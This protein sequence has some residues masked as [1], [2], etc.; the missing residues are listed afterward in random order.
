[1]KFSVII[2]ARLGST[3]LPNKILYKI[4]RYNFLE[5]LIKRLKLLKKINQIIVATTNNPRD[6]EII[7]IAK[8]NKVKFY[9]G[10]E[11]NVQKRVIDAGKKFKCETIVRITSDCPL[12][13]PDLIDQAVEIYRLNS[14]DYLSNTQKMRTYPDGMDI[15]IFSLNSL[16]RS[17][18]LNLSIKKKQWTT[19]SLRNNP[20][21]FKH[22]I[23]A[24]PRNLK[25]PD[26]HLTLDEY[27][28]YKLL[29][30]IILHFNEKHNFSCHEIISLLKKK[31]HWLKINKHIKRNY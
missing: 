12:S 27:E 30:K 20:K 15:E 8:K 6:K 7:R 1:M 26:L 13:D 31:K 28:D 22:L 11:N 25:W 10:S 4:K 17:S 2:E 24:A 16:I 9:V 5:F 23:L 18:K 29:K 3:R 19:W 14:C 21:K